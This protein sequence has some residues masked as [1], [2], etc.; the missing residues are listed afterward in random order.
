[1]NK[2]ATLI[3][4]AAACAGAASLPS[5]SSDDYSSDS[6]TGTNGTYAKCSIGERGDIHGLWGQV[7]F[8]Q[9]QGEYVSSM[10][11]EKDTEVNARFFNIDEESIY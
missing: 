8:Y 10:Y 2:F 3:L 9:P 5:G 4:A 6:A 11:I 7:V 1:M